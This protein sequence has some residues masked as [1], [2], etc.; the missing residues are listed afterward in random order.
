MN[1]SDYAA[2]DATGLADLV[3]RR[4]VSAEDVLDAAC[5]LPGV[6]RV[7]ALAF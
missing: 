3:R 2:Q 6:K 7:K 5:K 1:L 4:E